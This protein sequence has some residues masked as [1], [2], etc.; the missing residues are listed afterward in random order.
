MLRLNIRR[1]AQAIVNGFPKDRLRSLW[2]TLTRPST[3]DPPFNDLIV[4]AISL[5]SLL[6]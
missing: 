6:S 1:G 5:R 3:H 2:W 4:A